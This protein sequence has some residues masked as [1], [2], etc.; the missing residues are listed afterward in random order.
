MYHKEVLENGLRIV[1]EEI[2]YVRS[3]AIGIWVGVG[4]RDE[5]E[6]EHG[7]SHFLEHLMFKG[8]TN[9]SAKDIAE[10]LDAVGG[11][12]NAFTT[13]EYT[14]YYAKVLDEHLDLAIDVLSDMFFNSLFADKD[15]E[16]EKKVVL[17]EIK[18]Y[19]DSPDELVHDLFATHV[20]AKHSLGKPILGTYDSVAALTR[21]KVNIFY[22]NH[23]T[24]PN[25]VIAVAGKINH[26]QVVDKLKSAF[27]SLNGQAIK[28]N[29]GLPNPHQGVMC[30]EKTTEQ[31]QLCIGVPGLPQDSW[32]I[33]K[34][35]LINNILGGGLSSR[36]FQ[37]IREERA[38]AYS[39]YSYHSAFRD[40]GLFTIYSGTSPE[41]A[42]EVA[43]LVL[44]ELAKLATK[45]VDE[46]ELSRTKEQ[47]KGNIYLGLESVSSRMSRM[48][49]SELCFNRLITPEE[50]IDKIN[51]VTTDEVQEMA[52]Q[53]FDHSKIAIATIGPFCKNEKLEELIKSYGNC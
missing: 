50:V 1:S 26:Q 11:Q 32:D 53:L 3:V 30:T 42:D 18:M 2:P 40:C 33:Y 41:N 4:S 44:N 28:K 7:I 25:V 51:K 23:Y 46:Q 19:E 39:V 52:V 38:L 45:G 48:G 34:V 22:Q 49:K 12:L 15:I 24:N 31:L 8:T 36:L 21:D 37:E 20:W 14:C 10:A 16:K 17:E 27:A 9:R 43:E 6:G 47:I 35:H 29:I 5:T 13:K